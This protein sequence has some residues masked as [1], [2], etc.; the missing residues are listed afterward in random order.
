M[1]QT[2]AKAM[3]TLRMKR[4]DALLTAFLNNYPIVNT[5][6]RECIA[7]TLF[8]HSWELGH[9][10]FENDTRATGNKIFQE[11]QLSK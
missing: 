2:M 6:V 1:S 8:S 10:S 7:I 4:I 9:M 11:R 3:C 5:T